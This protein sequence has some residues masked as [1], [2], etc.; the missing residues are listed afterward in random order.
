MT[1]SEETR[2]SNF[3]RKQGSEPLSANELRTLQRLMAKKIAEQESIHSRNTSAVKERP[4]RASP[5]LVR[6]RERY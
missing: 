5:S 6:N 3:S 4:Q 1:K 2:L